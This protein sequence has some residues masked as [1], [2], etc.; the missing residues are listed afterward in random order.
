MAVINSLAIGR[1]KKSAGNLTYRTVRGRTIASQ[2]ISQGARPDMKNTAA[3]RDLSIISRFMAAHADDIAV[4]FS[5]TKFGTSRN[6]FMKLN[7]AALVQ[8]IMP[9]SSSLVPPDI[10][11]IENA[12][13]EY[14]IAHPT[15]IVRVALPGFNREYLAGAW[16]S[17]DNPVSGGGNQDVG[18]GKITATATAD[19]ASYTA[20]LGVSVAFRNGAIIER[21][22][23]S[24]VITAGTL[25]AGIASAADIIFYGGSGNPLTG[26]PSLTGIS[27]TVGRLSFVSNAISAA[28]NVQAVKIKDL[29]YRL[30][31]AYVIVGGITPDP[32]L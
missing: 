5:P 16:S 30:K 20:N 18:T 19:G 28:Q 9:I 29:F 22:A 23:S 31:S 13:T 6:H 10:A 21:P 24:I 14:A 4:S 17:S 26:Q 11:V 15:A 2:K 7:Y 1:S 12:V 32:E 8:A 25:P 3:G 27:S